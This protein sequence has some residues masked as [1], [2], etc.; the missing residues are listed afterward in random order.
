M[1]YS[2]FKSIMVNFEKKELPADLVV[3]CIGPQARSHM[4]EYFKTVLHMIPV[5]EY[6][7][8]LPDYTFDSNTLV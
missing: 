8:D 6:S 7:F 1:D 4:L 5:K 2:K 3:I